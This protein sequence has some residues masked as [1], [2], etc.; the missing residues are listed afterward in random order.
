MLTSFILETTDMTGN[1]NQVSFLD[2]KSLHEGMRTELIAAFSRVLDSGWYIRGQEVDAFEKEWANY[3][4]VNFCVGVSNG[5]DALH[6]ILRAY[7]IGH[8]D[9]VIV[10]SNTYIATWLAVTY[11]GAR[12]VPVEPDQHS[13]NI[14]PERISV[15]ITSRTK[16]II[17]VHL[18]GQL[19]DMESIVAIA[20]AKGI[21]VIEDA[22][23][24]HGASRA[25]Q[26]AGSFGDAAGFS[27]YPGKN[28][29]AIG[30]AGA[31]TTSDQKLAERIRAIGNYGSRVKYHNELLGLN[32]RLDE[33]QAAIL[34][35]KLP[36][37]EVWN[38]R[39][40]EIASAYTSRLSG[41]PGLALPTSAN[42]GS[43]VWHQFVVRHAMRDIL[44]SMLNERGIRT[45]IHYPIPPYRQQAYEH[46]RL[47]ASAFP[48]ADSMHHEALSL[49]IDPTM[50]DQSV[51][52]VAK[53][54]TESCV[55]LF[56]N[57]SVPSS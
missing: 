54:V 16:A 24:A 46:L 4:G 41:V 36:H 32:C 19:A 50:T 43:P 13:F 7:G 42:S 33:L 1:A 6:L 12:P 37:L 47:S 9:E 34:R 10:P 17:A 5:L 25:G 28:L 22:A 35:E 21:R 39:R 2:L 44:Q 53:A 51:D 3:C 45:M 56:E 29:G 11:A 26:R 31:V 27:F 57:P 20:R 55:H 52:A 18:Y 49:P 8:G 15:A 30:D 23:Q 38:Q 14:D 40:R 48:I